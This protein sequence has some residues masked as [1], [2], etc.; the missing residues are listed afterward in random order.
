VGVFSASADRRA[1]PRAGFSSR[2]E[3]FLRE[4]PL[5]ESLSKGSRICTAMMAQ[6]GRSEAGVAWLPFALPDSLL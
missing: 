4:S 6:A 2:R 3:K 1:G 5:K